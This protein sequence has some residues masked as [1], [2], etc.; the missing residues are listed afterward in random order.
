MKN[1][2]LACNLQVINHLTTV[3][4]KIIRAHDAGAVNMSTLVMCCMVKAVGS[5]LLISQKS[6]RMLFV[7][8]LL[9]I[10]ASRSLL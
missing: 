4:K 6:N 3:K 1:K 5:L 9:P 2:T 10:Q 7:L 8:I